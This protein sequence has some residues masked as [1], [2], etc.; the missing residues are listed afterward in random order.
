[1][2]MLLAVAPHIAVLTINDRGAS[3]SVTK[4]GKMCREKNGRK[5]CWPSEACSSNKIALFPAKIK[6]LPGPLP[7]KIAVHGAAA[8]PFCANGI[9]NQGVCTVVPPGKEAAWPTVK[10][11]SAKLLHL[12]EAADGHARFPLISGGVLLS[13]I[14][15]VPHERKLVFIALMPRAFQSP[16]GSVMNHTFPYKSLLHPL[17]LVP[18][19]LQ[20]N[21]DTFLGCTDAPTKFGDGNIDLTIAILHCKVAFKL[22]SNR[23]HLDGKVF[24]FTRRRL[25]AAFPFALQRNGW[26]CPDLQVGQPTAIGPMLPR[27]RPPPSAEKACPPTP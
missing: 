14:I 25:S 23:L 22:R 1:M 9:I 13:D 19:L 17:R 4:R 2:Q 10:S 7:A 16:I 11:A 27:A 8:D 18:T 15:W 26:R 24:D 21:P 6:P 12:H 5:Y 3:C 20:S